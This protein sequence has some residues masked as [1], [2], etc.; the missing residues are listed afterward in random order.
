LKAEM[1]MISRFHFFVLSKWVNV[2]RRY[3]EAQI[4]QT[5]PPAK[6]DKMEGCFEK[7]M[8]DV[9]RSLEARNRDR[10]TQNLTVFRHDAKA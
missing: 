6:R 4:A 3:A 2:L 10:F 8:S 7:L 5:M 1:L 9:T